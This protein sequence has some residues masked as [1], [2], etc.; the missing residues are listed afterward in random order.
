MWRNALFGLVD[1]I[2]VVIL[3]LES[4]F[5]L[6]ALG[7]LSNIISGDLVRLLVFLF[8]PSPVTSVHRLARLQF[9]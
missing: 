9:F 6:V 5:T 7:G 8:L 1:D 2:S 3:L 4:E